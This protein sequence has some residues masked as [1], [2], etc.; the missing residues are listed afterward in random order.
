GYPDQGTQ[1][2][3]RHHVTYALYPHAGDWRQGRSFAQ[4]DALNQPLIPF[5]ATPH[6]GA[7][8]KTFSLLHVSDPSVS[9]SAVKK[10]EES[11]EIVVRLRE[12]TG[13]AAKSVH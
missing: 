2:L 11:D 13:N 1:D 12:H 3:G 9:I 10:V 5:T 4:A 6:E 8:G 7:L